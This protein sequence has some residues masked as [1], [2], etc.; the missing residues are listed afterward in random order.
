[1]S[2]IIRSDYL[3]AGDYVSSVPINQIASQLHDEGN[4]KKLVNLTTEQCR[5]SYIKTFQSDYRNVLLV[6]DSNLDADVIDTNTSQ[7]VN[8]F[9]ARFASSWQCGSNQA[10]AWTCCESH[11]IIKD[12]IRRTPCP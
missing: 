7:V 4:S 12:I 3:L 1:M 9:D 6:S 8:W 11:F 5:T 10:F 2:G